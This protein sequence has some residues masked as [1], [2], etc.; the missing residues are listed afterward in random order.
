MKKILLILCALV[1]GTFA[2]AQ[3]EA[4][5]IDNLHMKVGSTDMGVMQG[6]V[7]VV[8]ESDAHD[9]ID[10]TLHDVD[11]TVSGSEYNLGDVTVKSV[12]LGDEENGVA[13]FSCS[14]DHDV[15]LS[16]PEWEELLEQ[17][18]YTVTVNMT[19]EISTDK[20]RADMTIDIKL[21]G[22]ISLATI[23]ATFGYGCDDYLIVNVKTG[24][25]LAGGLYWGTCGT[26]G[27]KPQFFTLEEQAD[28]TYTLD[29]HQTNGGNSHYLSDGLY[30][31]ADA[32]SWTL[33]AVDGGYH[34]SCAAGY[35]T[36]NGFQKE[37]TLPSTAGETAVWKLVTL[38]EAIAGMDEATISVPVD[39]T[40]L[41]PSC[42]PKRNAWGDV[43]STGAWTVTGYN[44]EDEPTNY[45]FG[46]GYTPASC[47]ESYHST[48]G[49]DIRQT[50]SLPKA[51]YYELTAQAFY[52][53]DG[54]DVIPSMYVTTGTS[55]SDTNGNF[56]N[57]HLPEH[58]TSSDG[59]EGAYQEFLEGL[60]PVSLPFVVDNDGDE[61]T[62]GFESNVEADD[63]M[64]SIFGEL[65][66]LYMGTELPELTAVT[67]K[68]N[69][70]VQTAMNEALAAYASG[71]TSA[72]FAAAEQAIIDA[73]ESIAYY[74]EITAAIES[75]DYEDVLK[76]F[77]AD[78]QAAFENGFLAAYNACTLTNE[79][80]EDGLAD[81]CKQ[82]TTEGSDMTYA[83]LNSGTWTGNT[84]TYDGGLERYQEANYT[85]GKILYKTIE[86]L[87]PGTYTVTFYAAANSTSDRGFSNIYGDNIA[88]AFANSATVDVTVINQTGC[89][90]SNYEYTI[91]CTVGSDGVL[92][93]GLQNIGTGGNWYVAQAVSLFLGEVEEEDP[94]IYNITSLLENPSFEDV[95]VTELTADGTRCD[96]TVGGAWTVTSLEGWDLVVPDNDWSFHDIMSADATATD[97][98]FGAPGTPSDGTYMLYLRD[99]NVTVNA[100]VEQSIVLPAGEYKLTVDT[101]CVTTSNSTGALVAKA[102]DETIESTAVAL[103][104]SYLVNEESLGWDTAV[105]TF[106]LTETTE[107][108]VGVDISF[109][110]NGSFLLDNF[111]LRSTEEVETVEYNYDVTWA[112]ANPSF[113]T[114]KVA[115]LT[116]DTG[117]SITDEDGNLV[118]ACAWKVTSLTGWTL[119]TLSGDTY[120]VSD[121]MTS[122]ATSTD[123]N[124]GVPGDP[125]NGSQML[126]IRDAWQSDEDVK[127]TQELTLPA[128]DYKIT[129]DTKCVANGSTA[130]LFVDDK[131]KALTI[132]STSNGTSE[133][134][135]NPFLDAWDTATLTFSLETEA[136]VSVGIEFDFNTNGSFLLDNFKLYSV[137][138]IDK[139]ISWTMTDAG[140]GTM[141]LPFDATLED[142]LTAYSCA[143]TTTDEETETT[144]VDLTEVGQSITANTPYVIKC[145]DDSA[146]KPHSFTGTPTNTVETYTVGILTGTLVDLAIAQG[147]AL[148]TD[149]TNYVLQNHTDDG[150]G[151]AFYPIT[152]ASEGVTL[153]AY[154]CYLDLSLV[155][156]SARPVAL[157]FPGS[158]E[159]TGIE[160][161]ESELI[162]N[163]A[164]YDLSGRRVAKAVK[165]VYIMNGKKVLVK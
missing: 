115:N 78:G 92:E 75:G 96:T 9:V 7:T 153:D 47:A 18:L 44:E 95:D 73:E 109:N 130:T 147:A 106:T 82:Q 156:T 33:D 121:L 131:S 164:I 119:P 72:T 140:W 139:T 152:S 165:G 10:F 8:Y 41:I 126:Y 12:I 21:L 132:H 52:R 38:E 57:K 102:G 154:H 136:T 133:T 90:L 93:F 138:A 150:E 146:I 46:A 127:L 17:G 40:P 67:G 42:E 69:A 56:E 148:A 157:H 63:V 98:G 79:T 144:T 11:V 81:A 80:I 76:T 3:T 160:A 65:G 2:F 15:A 53:N 37:L 43:V 24:N 111:Q 94:Y 32:T 60:Y 137:D 159:T 143:G 161:V 149:G 26:E 4:T 89:T 134:A 97:N 124:Y 108:T 22:T 91:K 50:F 85:A 70:D 66:L 1:C 118:T 100:S 36:G 14:D 112:L 99:G 48:N 128:G 145:T 87:T 142:G 103:H 135:S 88:Q 117:R 105:L 114:D 29:S 129:V 28:G 13:S 39:V 58:N 55:A 123:N 110:G 125:S 6:Q 61:I 155:T 86:G 23:T 77:D 64:W 120:G 162:A 158:G 16:D 113:E 25:Y 101:K 27:G 83:V 62:V 141:I 107:V 104:T 54:G 5:Y 71:P 74:A 151:V 122:G 49:F 116:V 59:M 68:M 45:A 84:G 31:D 20:L 30:V 19:G 35:L 163:D 51:G 34:I